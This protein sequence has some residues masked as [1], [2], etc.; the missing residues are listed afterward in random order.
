[1]CQSIIAAVSATTSFSDMSPNSFLNHTR[2]LSFGWKSSG[3]GERGIGAFL[4]FVT[5]RGV[6]FLFFNSFNIEPRAGA[7][8]LLCRADSG[9]EGGAKGVLKGVLTGL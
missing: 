9:P 7:C 4:V 2:S 8:S 3:K 1:M 5:S 6:W